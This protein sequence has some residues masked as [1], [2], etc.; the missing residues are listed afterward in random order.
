MS[1]ETEPKAALWLLKNLLLIHIRG[2]ETED[3]FSLTEFWGP[4]GDQPPPHV[5]NK[6]DEGFYVL[7]GEITL[8]LPDREI[9]IRKGEFCN[10]PRG[11]PH[12]Y[13]VT[14]ETEARWLITSVPAG[15]EKFLEEYGE[16]ADELRLPDAKP[17]DIERLIETSGKQDIEVLGPPGVLPKDLPAAG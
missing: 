14:S 11:V 3:H 5:H 6:Q 4:P 2:D 9:L 17:P 7:E 1:K 8:F 16:P 10:A 15:I 12:T 13:R